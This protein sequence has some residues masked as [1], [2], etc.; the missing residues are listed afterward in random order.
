MLALV[1][2]LSSPLAVSVRSPGLYWSQQ[3]PR[4]RK[5]GLRTQLWPWGFP[6]GRQQTATLAS[7][8]RAHSS[9]SQL[10]SARL[11]AFTTSFLYVVKLLRVFFSPLPTSSQNCKLNMLPFINPV[12]PVSFQNGTS[13]GE[14]RTQILSCPA[15]SE[16]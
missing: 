2:V 6:A 14:L 12:L 9:D 4:M 3:E 5:G 1:S 13:N 7:E 8:R 10:K 15:N 11:P 16:F